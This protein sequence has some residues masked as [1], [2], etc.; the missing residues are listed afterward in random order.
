MTG[1]QSCRQLKRSPL[2]KRESL[3]C[4]PSALVYSLSRISSPHLFMTLN[5][6]TQM[7]PQ[8][9][10]I[11][12]F[13][14]SP[15]LANE[16]IELGELKTIK[17]GKT[18]EAQGLELDKLIFIFSGLVSVFRQNFDGAERFVGYIPA[19][20]MYGESAILHQEKSYARYHIQETMTALFI[21]A[22]ETLRLY[23]SNPEFSKII[24]NQV[25]QKLLYASKILLIS[26]ERDLNRKVGLALDSLFRVTQKY[27]LPI[28]IENLAGLLGMSRNTVS[29]TL[30][31]WQSEGA[32][33]NNKANI[34]FNSPEPFS[35]ITD[36]KVF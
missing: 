19:G 4:T 28:S 13:N 10:L 6:R 25:S 33:T 17:S 8:D 32:I 3:Q 1:G 26:H 2:K 9:T 15:E 34:T 14:L 23:N 29:K 21:P 16:L 7:L 24:A 30:N 5:W 20:F 11:S 31:Y 22:S 18:L 36:G 27:S 35:T 12:K